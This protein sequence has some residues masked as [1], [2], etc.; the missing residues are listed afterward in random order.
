MKTR[1]FVVRILICLLL[2]F[3][4]LTDLENAIYATRFKIRGKPES[5]SPVLIVEVPSNEFQ[6]TFELGAIQDELKGPAQINIATKTDGKVFEYDAD[7]FVRRAAPRNAAAR[8]L[9]I[10][11]RGPAG[12]VPRCTLKDVRD[13]VKGC[14]IKG[15]NVLLVDDVEDALDLRTPV[16]DLSRAEVL[17]NAWATTLQDRSIQ[18]IPFWVSFLMIVALTGAVAFY[19]ISYSVIIHSIAASGTAFILFG[20]F[21]AAFQ[22]LNVYIPSANLA[23]SMLITY[24]VFS[25]FRLA[26]QENL[27]WRS[28]KKAEYIRELDE[29]KTNFLSLVSHDLKTPI[30]KIQAVTERLVRENRL[31]PGQRSD[32]KELFESIEIS[33]NELKHYI[34]SILNLSKIESQKVILNKKSNDINVLIQQ[35]LKRLAPLAQ[36][37]GIQ[38]EAQLEPLFSVECDEDLMKQVISNLVDNAIKYSPPQS[39]II[40]QSQDENTAVRVS[41]RDFGPGISKDLL[42]QMFRKFSRLTSQ[43]PSESIKGSGLGLYL[44]KY[45]IELHGGSIRVESGTGGPDIGTTFSFTLPTETGQN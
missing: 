45:F 30:A 44:S 18:R 15:R 16:G 17:A 26:H 40:V 35:S 29:M 6:S 28:M 11:F 9:W 42:P 39:R 12:S 25:G 4:P 2:S 19:I 22:Y 3:I 38:I 37:R 36:Q 24:L 1:A 27:Q 5:P 31:P 21:Q 10:N 7:G 34:T 33:N 14:D 41:V 13:L 20:L 32:W 8:P 23:A 43:N